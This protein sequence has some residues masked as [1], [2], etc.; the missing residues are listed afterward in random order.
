MHEG[1]IIKYYREQQSLTQ[2]KLCHGICS[3]AHMSRIERGTAHYSKEIT[4]LLSNRL[5]VNIAS[6]VKKF[7][8]LKEMLRLWHDAMIMQDLEKTE[9]Y[10]E[11]LEKNDLLSRSDLGHLYQLLQVRYYLT[12]RDLKEAVRLLKKTEIK[13]HL[14]G[15]KELHMFYHMSGAYCLYT[16]EYA[17]ALGFFKQID[18][19]LY[20]N[21]EFYYHLAIT[22]HRFGHHVKAYEYARTS[23][24]FFKQANHFR[25]IIDAETLILLTQGGYIIQ[26][27]IE[28]IKKKYTDLIRSCDLFGEHVKKAVLLCN[29]GQEYFLIF[30]NREANSYYKSALDLYKQCNH[31]NYIS[32]LVGYIHTSYLLKDVETQQTLMKLVQEGMQVAKQSGNIGDTKKFKLLSYLIKGQTKQ[33]H[34]YLHESFIPYLRKSGNVT[35]AG[36]YEKQLF[37]YYVA[38]NENEKASQVAYSYIKGS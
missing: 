33:Y 14:L 24:H 7:E 29:L 3:V 4:Q 5:G 35:T 26:N 23:L 2:H 12:N 31:Q 20:Q 16:G 30:N 28:E 34:A 38:E 1:L 22:C 21:N 11:T 6:E 10:K 9:V 8:K 15:D 19:E 27:D 25:K 32:A 13:R 18:S 37:Q 17:K 36:Y